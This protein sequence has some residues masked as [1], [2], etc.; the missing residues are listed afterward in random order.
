[1]REL[2]SLKRYKN[3]IPLEYLRSIGGND[4]RRCLNKR[5]YIALQKAILRDKIDSDNCIGDDEEFRQA[6][7]AGAQQY[8]LTVQEYLR[9]E[10]LKSIEF[11][12]K[13]YDVLYVS[14]SAFSVNKLYENTAKYC[15]SAT[16]RR[17]NTPIDEYD[18]EHETIALAKRFE[19]QFNEALKLIR[20]Q[21]EDVQEKVLT[22]HLIGQS[23]LGYDFFRTLK[24]AK[25]PEY[26]KAYFSRMGFGNYKYLSAEAILDILSKA[27][28]RNWT[29]PFVLFYRTHKW[30]KV[31]SVFGAG[32]LNKWCAALMAALR[33]P[34]LGRSLEPLFDLDLGETFAINQAR[35]SDGTHTI[36]VIG[37]LPSIAWENWDSMFD[38]IARLSHD[39]PG[40]I[41]GIDFTGY[42]QTVVGYDFDWRLDLKTELHN[43]Y[44]WMALEY[45]YADVYTGPWKV[46]L[47]EFKSGSPDTQFGGSEKHIDLNY[48]V[49]KDVGAKLEHCVVLSDDDLAFIKSMC[50]YD[51]YFNGFK[52]YGFDVNKTKTTFKTKH[53]YN[54]F[55]NNYVGPIISADV[56]SVLGDPIDR[57]YGLAHVEIIPDV[58]TIYNI[59]SNIAVDQILSKWASN[60][61]D[62]VPLIESEINVV[63]GTV[64]GNLA[65]RGVAALK[66]K[67]LDVT[68]YRPDFIVGFHPMR[69]FEKVT[70]PSGKQHNLY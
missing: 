21:S 31:R 65:I 56:T 14:K 52:R 45:K 7:Y 68:L 17:K 69:V 49:T 67:A 20:D 42:D 6:I 57:Y 51:D 13:L 16:I 47:I 35:T 24:K 26:S 15:T 37:K 60:S 63:Q 34:M 33:A 62:G 36:P 59:S 4:W 46:K 40:E 3:D 23:N 5:N 29:E 9:P 8:A 38:R 50:H 27:V 54:K 10:F 70:L 41:A 39:Y 12:Q 19:L 44:A 66:S 43:Y 22:M 25:V 61:I 1:M 18:P 55:L 64:L 11:P 32:V 2:S 58:K 28:Q 48:K 53:E 30:P